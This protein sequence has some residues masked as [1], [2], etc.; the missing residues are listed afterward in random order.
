MEWEQSQNILDLR[1]IPEDTEFDQEPKDVCAEMPSEHDFNPEPFE[2]KALGH[3][4]VGLSWDEE[5]N[6]D[7]LLL[8][9]RKFNKQELENMDYSAY[10]ASDTDDSLSED[11]DGGGSARGGMAA[12][13]AECQEAE[14]EEAPQDNMEVTWDLGLKERT[15]TALKRREERLAEAGMT[16]GEKHE[17][18]QKDKQKARKQLIKERIAASKAGSGGNGVD[19]DSDDEDMTARAGGDDAFFQ[20]DFGDGFAPRGAAGTASRTAIASSDDDSDGNEDGGGNELD[21]DALAAAAGDAAAGDG[22]FDMRQIAKE[23]KL[24]KKKKK[25]LRSKSK[26]GVDDD[27]DAQAADDSFKL[28]VGDSRFGAVFD[29]KDFAIDKTV[30]EFKDTREMSRLIDERQARVRKATKESGKKRKSE[31]K[32]KAASSKKHTPGPVAPEDEDGILAELVAS[33]KD[34]YAKGGPKN[35]RFK[36][37]TRDGEGSRSGLAGM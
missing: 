31:K 12:L 27:E 20:Q 1:Y 34:K 19:S 21:A 6:D 16:I 28:D 5:D 23:H 26:R 36:G 30:P 33:V 4:K 32:A 14:D 8:T 24:S 9:K 15:E 37:D 25:K 2:T 7:K 11:E 13:L 10:L 3:T 22:H 35:K 18:K 17:K 29:N